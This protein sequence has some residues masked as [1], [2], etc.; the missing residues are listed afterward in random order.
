MKYNLSESSWSFWLLIMKMGMANKITACMMFCKDPL[1]HWSRT[2]SCWLCWKL[3]RGGGTLKRSQTDF[4]KF[5]FSPAL[6]LWRWSLARHLQTRCFFLSL[7]CFP[8]LHRNRCCPFWF[9]RACLFLQMTS[10]R[11]LF[12]NYQKASEKVSDGGQYSKN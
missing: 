3:W 6:H 12:R 11:V 7:S 5:F 4:C 8:G 2:A 10:M 1:P 9:L